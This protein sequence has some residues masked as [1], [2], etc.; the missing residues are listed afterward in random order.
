MHKFIK[1]VPLQKK[2]MEYLKKLKS[3][4]FFLFLSNVLLA[5][6]ARIDSLK[7]VLEEKA[8]LSDT[9][10]FCSINYLLEEYLYRKDSIQSLYYADLLIKEASKK[11][12][13]LADSLC[14]ALVYI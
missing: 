8:S 6:S 5:Q 1:N 3:L 10:V 14:Q 12:D 11:K 7:T 13:D 9:E 4:F 2:S